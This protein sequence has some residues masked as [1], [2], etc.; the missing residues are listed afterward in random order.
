ML[1]RSCSQFDRLQAVADANRREQQSYVQKQQQLQA[2]IEQVGMV[3]RMLGS[4]PA[5]LFIAGRRA[6]EHSFPA[7]TALWLASSHCKGV[8]DGASHQCYTIRK[9]WCFSSA[10]ECV[11]HV[12]CAAHLNF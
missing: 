8:I 5:V 11:A 6:S 7:M 2:E 1:P 9:K 12:V 4:S 3:E 10:A